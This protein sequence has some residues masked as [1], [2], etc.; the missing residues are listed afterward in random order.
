MTNEFK[1]KKQS[2]EQTVYVLEC[3]SGGTTTA[4]A[5]ASIP[6][7]M[8]DVQKRQPSAVKK[9][10]T[11]MPQQVVPAKK[12]KG[13][14]PDSRSSKKDMA[15]LSENFNHED[16]GHYEQEMSMA[17]SELF[18][19]AKN[20]MHLLKLLKNE[21][22]LEAWQQSKITKAADYLDAVYKSIDYDVSVHDE[23]DVDTMEAHGHSA[24]QQAAIAIHKQDMHEAVDVNAIQ[25]QIEELQA[26]KEI[27]IQ[28]YKE[29]RKISK[30]TISG[31]DDLILDTLTQTK[32]IAKKLGIP[33]SDFK[34]EATYVYDTKQNFESAIYNL[35]EMF[36]DYVRDIDFEINR[37]QDEIDYPDEDSMAADAFNQAAKKESINYDGY[38]ASLTEQLDALLT[39]KKAPAKSKKKPNPYAIGMAAAKKSAGYGEKPVHDLPKKV[40]T[41]GHEIAKKIKANKK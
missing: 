32:N 10:V 37:L 5:V 3:S 26:K 40:I 29:S 27:G 17:Q 9:A 25:Q 11:R 19:A 23:Q 28:A 38:F 7:E 30:S 36:D 31:L 41:K 33:D 22:E 2:D 16:E 13:S 34:S 24:K 4:G 20:A 1:V 15:K 8:G 6:M 12:G 14:N 35:E 18:S 39:E 21:N